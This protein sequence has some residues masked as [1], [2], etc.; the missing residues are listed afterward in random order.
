MAA[1]MLEYILEYICRI[2]L[3]NILA[4]VF[5]QRGQ[6]FTADQVETAVLLDDEAVAHQQ[7]LPI[8]LHSSHCQCHAQ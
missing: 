3:W 6:A 4:S 7:T 1:S 5:W 8:V 2:Y